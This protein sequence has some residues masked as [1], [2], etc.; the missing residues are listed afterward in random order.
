M[1]H[2]VVFS[3]LPFSSEQPGGLNEVASSDRTLVLSLLTLAQAV[4]ECPDVSHLPQD[5]IIHHVHSRLIRFV[6]CVTLLSRITTHTTLS[7]PLSPLLTDLLLQLFASLSHLSQPAMSD[8]SILHLS[9]WCA[10]LRAEPLLPRAPHLTLCPLIALPS[11][12]IELV[13][14]ANAARCPQTGMWWMLS[15]VINLSVYL[16]LIIFGMISS[17]VH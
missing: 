16:F 2:G 3:S 17:Y 12:L 6:R 15:Y 5:G 8:S 11:S 9:H 13:A 10:P 1:H 7:A 4:P 14:R